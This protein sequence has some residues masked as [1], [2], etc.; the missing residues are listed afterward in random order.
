MLAPP[1]LFRAPSS[2]D[3]L[4]DFWGPHGCRIVA[5]AA[6]QK[7]YTRSRTSNPIGMT[8]D[9][10]SN[11]SL[12]PLLITV[13]HLPHRVVFAIFSE[14]SSNQLGQEPDRHELRSQENSHN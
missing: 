4:R 6:R 2:S 9:S 11:T 1:R 5:F 8:F 3:T 13:Y 7:Y 12:L 14:I 10:V